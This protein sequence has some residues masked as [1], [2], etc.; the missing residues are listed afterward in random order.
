MAPQAQP[1]EN[2]SGT[3]SS[4]SVVLLMLINEPHAAFFQQ[5]ANDI[6]RQ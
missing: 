2:L 1:P 3:I 5:P 6:W 4:E